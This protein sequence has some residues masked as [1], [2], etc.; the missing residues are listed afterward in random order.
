M[1]NG[2]VDRNMFSL[3][4]GERHEVCSGREAVFGDVKRPIVLHAGHVHDVT[5]RWEESRPDADDSH[6]GMP[7]DSEVV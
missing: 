7:A 4:E 5:A 6:A 2:A 1:N 3:V